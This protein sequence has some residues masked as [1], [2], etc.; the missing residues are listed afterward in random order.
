MTTENE[1]KKAIR[2]ERAVIQL[3]P[4]EHA[5]LTERA[6]ED[7]LSLSTYVRRLIL[8]DATTRKTI[9]Y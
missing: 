7:G 8:K 3:T 1:G 6:A 5:A 4:E 9:A 2:T